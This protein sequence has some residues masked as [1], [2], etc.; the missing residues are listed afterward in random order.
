MSNKVPADERDVMHPSEPEDSRSFE[1]AARLYQ[2]RLR[3][4]FGLR[5]RDTSRVDDLIQETF[6]IFCQRYPAGGPS[7]P[8]YF[9]LK[10]IALNVLRNEIRKR[11]PNALG[12]RLDDLATRHANRY[13]DEEE[14]IEALKACLDEFKDRAVMRLVR[15]RYEEDLP[16]D[17]L[18]RREGKS[19]KADSVALTRVRKALRECIDRRIRSEERHP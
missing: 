2:G 16:I 4:F 5:L 3:A 11:R 1:E 19:S 14:L 9:W 12:D 13:D 17:V 8:I 6:L 18:A 15:A 10:G 7:A